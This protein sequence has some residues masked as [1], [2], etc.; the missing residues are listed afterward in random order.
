MTQWRSC[1]QALGRS[2]QAGHRPTSALTQ[3]I[4]ARPCRAADR[5]VFG[6]LQG[7]VSLHHKVSAAARSPYDTLSTMKF[8]YSVCLM[9]MMEIHIKRCRFCTGNILGQRLKAQGAT[10]CFKLRSDLFYIHYGK[11]KNAM[12]SFFTCLKDTMCMNHEKN[13]D[14]GAMIN[15]PSPEIDSYTFKLRVPIL[16]FPTNLHLYTSLNGTISM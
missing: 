12:P 14:Q 16:S 10:S 6:G 9:D 11:K 5:C 3:F 7:K 1:L 8:I 13:F 15:F 4:A 2:A